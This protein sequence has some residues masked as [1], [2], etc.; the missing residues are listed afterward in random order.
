MKEVCVFPPRMSVFVYLLVFVVSFCVFASTPRDD[1]S[2]SSRSVFYTLYNFASINCGLTDRVIKIMQPRNL[3]QLI[4]H[5]S[6]IAL[7]S[8]PGEGITA[9]LFDDE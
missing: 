1:S 6:E 5:V 7:N 8:F 4:G 2:D 3:A 9:C